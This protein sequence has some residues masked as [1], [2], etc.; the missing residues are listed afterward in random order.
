[1]KHNL[2]ELK[3]WNKAMDLAVDVYTASINF[4][5]KEKFGL[6]SQI[7]RCAVSVPSNIAEGAGRNSDNEFNHFLGI[8]H[9]SSYELQTQIILSNRLNLLDNDT[10]E[11]LINQVT[12]I[13]KMNYKLR[14]SISYRNQQK[15][16]FE[17]KAI[18]RSKV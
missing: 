6:T 15:N 9:G 2:K 13:Q 10:S 17:N 18:L 7:R 1:M 4:P 12:E 11:K 14:D 3:I 16:K 5:T 8:S